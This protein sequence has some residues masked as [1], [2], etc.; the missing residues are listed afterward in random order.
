MIF[1]KNLLSTAQ[2]DIVKVGDDGKETDESVKTITF[3]QDEMNLLKSGGTV[4][5][6]NDVVNGLESMTTYHVKISLYAEYLSKSYQMRTSLTKTEFKT[7][8]KDPEI[9]VTNL[10][11]KAGH[12]IFDVS[13]NDPDETVLEDYVTVNLYKNGNTFV[14]ATKVNKNKNAVTIDFSNIDNDAAYTLY[15]IAKQYNNGYNTGTLKSNYVIKSMD[16]NSESG[17]S[18]SIKLQG[19]D[20][21]SGNAEQYNARVNVKVEDLKNELSPQQF[22]LRVEKDGAI[23]EDNSY[24]M[25]EKLGNQSV[26]GR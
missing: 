26:C 8:K 17:I 15:F 11:A 9:V 12:I 21:I 18:G 16:V 5:M 25:P 1:L 2:I 6:S 7:M 22:Y 4:S 23:I 10:I 13:V 24:A 3:T 14:E 19:L 20:V